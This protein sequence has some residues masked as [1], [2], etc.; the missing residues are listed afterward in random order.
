MRRELGL[1]MDGGHIGNLYCPSTR[2]QLALFAIFF[3]NWS[4]KSKIQ[5]PVI[6][7]SATR[8]DPV[9]FHPSSQLISLTSVLVLSYHI[10]GLQIS[11]FLR[12]FH[13]AWSVDVHA[14]WSPDWLTKWN[15][16]SLE[17]LIAAHLVK[18]IPEFYGT[19]S[20][21]NSLAFVPIL[22]QINLDETFHRIS[23]RSIQFLSTYLLLGLP[24]GLFPSRFPTKTLW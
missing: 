16:V 20:V 21:N 12:Y 17:K 8:H 11:P 13:C 18:K 14:A 22:S 6:S 9:Q 2:G 15:R 3:T 4:L 24:N 1:L 19:R 7:K 5:K 23:L 10:H